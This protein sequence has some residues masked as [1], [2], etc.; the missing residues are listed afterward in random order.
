[1]SRQPNLMPFFQGRQ[2]MQETNILHCSLVMKDVVELSSDVQIFV[3]SHLEG[4]GL[5]SQILCKV[6]MFYLCFL[7]VPLCAMVSPSI[8]HML[9]LYTLTPLSV[10]LSTPL[11]YSWSRCKACQVWVVFRRPIRLKLR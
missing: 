2:K 10:L 6:C 4:C 8:K 3:S 5:D 11:P 9:I 7:E 1:M